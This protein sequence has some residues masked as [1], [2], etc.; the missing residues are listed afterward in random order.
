MAPKVG[1]PVGNGA[2]IK[3]ILK[4]ADEDKVEVL[5]LPELCNSGYV[6]E[7]KEEALA[8]SEVIG[9]G[10]IS[11]I[12]MEWSE[13]DRL[14]VAGICEQAD[15]DLFNSAAVFAKGEH[16][17]TYRKLH[18]FLNEKDIFQPGNE[19]PPVV[20]FEGDKYGIM[21]CFDW[22][23][24]EVARILALKGAEVILHP[25]N[26]VL[27]YCQ[28]AMITRSIENGVFT[29][30]ANRIGT[31]REVTFSGTSQLTGPKGELIKQMSS[32]KAG[33]TWADIKPEDAR[34]K[35]ITERNHI[36]HDRRP[37]IYSRLARR[38]DD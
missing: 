28:K 7:S 24:P 9:E 5:V 25:A 33:V 20:Q 34:N 23:F 22:A 17:T 36:L 11:K 31:E 14:L 2:R 10:R 16:I 30:T 13:K 12:L 8:S 1:D 35:M 29:A 18:L 4:L 19:E 38:P 15:G 27:P 32:E 21:V 3:A 26:L 6:F 37:D